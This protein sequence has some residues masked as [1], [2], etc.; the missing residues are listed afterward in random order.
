MDGHGKEEEIEGSRKK[1]V[2]NGWW[3]IDNWQWTIDDGGLTMD[4]GWL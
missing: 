1:M 2:D 4:N 3:T